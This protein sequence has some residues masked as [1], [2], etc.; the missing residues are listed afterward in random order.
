MHHISVVMQLYI[1]WS[2]WSSLK[3]NL[4]VAQQNP[5][6]RMRGTWADG[7][8]EL[9]MHCYLHMKNHRDSSQFKLCTR[10]SF[11]T[12]R[13]WCNESQEISVWVTG[14]S[15]FPGHQLVLSVLS[16]RTSLLSIRTFYAWRKT[17]LGAKHPAA[18]SRCGGCGAAIFCGLRTV[19]VP[20]FCKHLPV[21]PSNTFL[22]AIEASECRKD[23]TKS[24][25]VITSSGTRS[26]LLKYVSMSNVF[27]FLGR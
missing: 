6:L 3:N 18:C 2:Q 5:V 26:L 17:R 16:L 15:Q 24:Q 4:Y 25:V 13:C 9:R 23:V 27:F 22:H 12:K 1:P 8:N 7:K 10:F 20:L 14:A 19:F 11:G 21:C